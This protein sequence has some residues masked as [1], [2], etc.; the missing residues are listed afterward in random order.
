MLSYCKMP[1]FFL[2]FFAKLYVL[3]QFGVLRRLVDHDEA[4]YFVQKA[5]KRGT[6]TLKSQIACK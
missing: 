6:G 4:T 5:T 3:E 1:K 2:N